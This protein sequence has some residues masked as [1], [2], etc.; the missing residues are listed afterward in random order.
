MSFYFP[1]PQITKNPARAKSLGKRTL[2]SFPVG[3]SWFG[4]MG[5]FWHGGR[6]TVQKEEQGGCLG[7]IIFCVPAGV[8]GSF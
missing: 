6:T 5:A 4:Y 1:N 2:L 3:T 7:R 8:S